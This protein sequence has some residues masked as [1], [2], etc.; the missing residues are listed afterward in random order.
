[1]G[2]DAQKLSPAAFQSYWD[3]CLSLSVASFIRVGEGENLNKLMCS[4]RLLDTLTLGT[5]A[6]PPKNLGYDHRMVVES[7]MNP[8]ARK[9]SY[10]ASVSSVNILNIDGV[11]NFGKR[12]GI[13]V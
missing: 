1:M 11:K 13:R 8:Q 6:I 9:L 7:H 5:P 10:M 2:S 12:R 3:V 4:I